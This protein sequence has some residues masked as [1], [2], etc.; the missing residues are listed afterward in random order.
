[1]FKPRD[2]R[3]Q[4]LRPLIE[5]IY[6]TIYNCLFLRKKIKE[7]TFSILCNLNSEG[8]LLTRRK[9]GMISYKKYFFQYMIQY[10]NYLLS[11]P[12]L[13]KSGIIIKLLNQEIKIKT[14][15]DYI[16]TNTYKKRNETSFIPRICANVITDYI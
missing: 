3:L 15:Y 14:F 16:H 6:V 10:M 9:L 4:T 12:L 5:V 2:I 7:K 11:L 8:E 13:T 1:M